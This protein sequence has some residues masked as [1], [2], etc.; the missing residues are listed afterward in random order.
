MIHRLIHRLIHRVAAALALLGGLVLV[1]LTVLTV[2]SVTGRALIPLGLDSIPGAYELVELGTAFAIFAFLPW[3]Q[4]NRG[5]VT[6]DL[7]MNAAGFRANR[8]ADLA[9]N[10]LLTAAAAVLAWRLALGMLDKQRFGETTYIL[11]LPLWIGYAAALA[12]AALFVLVSA[13]T[14]WRS[15]AELKRGRLIEP[16]EGAPGGRA[17]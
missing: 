14:V 4:L 6:V 16:D 2:L 10:L 17:R 9:A 15:A 1:A 13:Y 5:H 8:W 11:G 12:G 3:C 7:V